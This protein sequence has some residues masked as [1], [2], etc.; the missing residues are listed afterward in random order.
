MAVWLTEKLI[1][2]LKRPEQRGERRSIIIY[3]APDP[4]GKAGWIS[5]FGIRATVGGA[6]AFILT[7]RN[8]NRQE[9][10]MTIGKWPIWSVEAARAEARELK[11]KIAKGA[12]PLAEI[13]AG[14]EAP[15]VSDLCDRFIEEHLPKKRPKTQQD[16]ATVIKNHIKPELGR[17]QVAVV[18]TADVEKLHRKITAAGAPTSANRALAVTSKMM[19]L[20]IKWKMRADNPC[21]GIE[22]NQETK[23]T[24]HLV[25]DELARLSEALAEHEDQNTANALR[26]LMLT[27]AR[28]SEVLQARWDQFDLEAG[29]WTKPAATTKQ[30][31]EHRVPL[32]APVLRLLRDLRRNADAEAGMVFPRRPGLRRAWDAVCRR[33]N[34][35]GLRIHDLRHSYASALAGQ[36][37]SLPVIGA[38]LG[39]T[40]ASTTQRYAHLLDDPLRAATNK[41]GSIMSGVVGKRPKG[42]KSLSVVAGGK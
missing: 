31:A 36:G 12:D 1:R 18:D 42:K 38:L 23:R 28:K 3:D 40:Q 30:K 19:T 8:K 39:H 14:R 5:G 29:V 35:T 34:I 22:R 20:A 26:M 24:R 11:A 2:D 4:K 17:K 27:G 41:V 10:R 21:K 9:R 7:Y 6:R 33:A 16:Y 13:K 15:T 32:S 25:G 37:F